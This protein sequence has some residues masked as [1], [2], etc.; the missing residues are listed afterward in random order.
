MILRGNCAIAIISQNLQNCY[1]EVSLEHPPDRK[2]G[3]SH[4][5][6]VEFLP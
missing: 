4:Q 6:K 2:L 5:L 1:P 3:I